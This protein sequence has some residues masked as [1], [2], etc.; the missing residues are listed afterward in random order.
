MN[1]DTKEKEKEKKKRKQTDSAS[2]SSSF[3]VPPDIKKFRKQLDA[4]AKNYFK[5]AE[6]KLTELN[7]TAKVAKEA[8]LNKSKELETSKT[9]Y[10]KDEFKWLTVAERLHKHGFAI[11]LDEPPFEIP[12]TIRPF[13]NDDLCWKPVYL[14]CAE[15]GQHMTIG[16]ESAGTDWDDED[17]Y[18]TGYPGWY[19]ND[20][21]LVNDHINVRDLLCEPE[22]VVSESL[23]HKDDGEIGSEGELWQ[24]SGTEAILISNN[25][26]DTVILTLTH[27]LLPRLDGPDPQLLTSLDN[28]DRVKW[29]RLFQPP[30]KQKKKQKL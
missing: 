8:A 18:D 27:E 16:R 14:S 10:R 28:C 29:T 7:Q 21:R 12:K 13:L 20:Y 24:V 30:F 23:E 17:R 5:T 19:I 6:S 9:E 1:T 26:W 3:L 25:K 15:T 11:V 4:D 2:S 22:S